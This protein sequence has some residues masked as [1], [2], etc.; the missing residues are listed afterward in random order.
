[1]TK[2]EVWKAYVKRNPSFNGDGK[3]TMSARGLRKMFDN[4]WEMAYEAGFNQECEDDE[5]DYSGDNYSKLSGNDTFNHIF[6]TIF[7][8][9]I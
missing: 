8:K 6:G 7:G 4:T 5:V 3:I 9:K 2:K 1:M